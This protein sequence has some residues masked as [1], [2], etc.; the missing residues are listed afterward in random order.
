MDK[1]KLLLIMI[2]LIIL[3][4]CIMAIIISLQSD[5]NYEEKK[6]MTDMVEGI[7]KIQVDNQ[8]KKVE[9]RNNFY[10]V[11]NCVKK[12]YSYRMEPE[13]SEEEL[14]DAAVLYNLLDK[15]YINFKNIT[16]ENI[17][18]I[19]PEIKTSVIDITNMYVSEQKLDL[20]IYIVK[21]TLR[22]KVSGKISEFQIMLK[23]DKKNKSFSVFLEDYMN[24][25]YK[26]IKLGNNIL[27]D[28]IANIERNEDNSYDYE[29]ISDETYVTD[30]FNKYKEEVL[31]NT[32]LAYEYLDEEYKSLKFETLE[33]FQEYAKNNIKMNVTMKLEQYN[34]TV[35]DRYT[36][37]ICIDQNGKYYIF[38]EKAVMDYSLILD[39]YTI[40]L[41]EFIEEYNKVTTMEKV[42][43]NIQ[44]CID[45][46]N[47][48]DYSYVYNK[49]DNDFK[50]NNYKTEASFIKAIQ[51]NLF[52][53]NKVESVS[54]SHEGNTYIYRLNIEDKEDSNKNKN[55]TI[56]MKLKEGTDFVMSF[57]FE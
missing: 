47:D 44:K 37:Y 49:L 55:M 32:K 1:K 35:E 9:V 22:E 51:D 29:S 43:F 36:Q 30:L 40:D 19:L 14:D 18:K 16:K 3:I 25:K 11:K 21:G 5:E 23:I 34:K 10:I 42:G 38:R 33:K 13:Y 48:K 27:I 15:E 45:A 17:S 41:P 54:S 6:E 28:G 56:I 26:D 53:K 50:N 52:N 8:L 20:S 7:V 12:F 46:M 31:Y 57:S 2:V 24:Q 4:V 39:T